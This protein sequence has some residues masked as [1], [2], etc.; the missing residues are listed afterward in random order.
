MELKY[1]HTFPEVSVE[2]FEDLLEDKEF[3]QQLEKLPNVSKR[4]LI[5]E[6]DLGGGKRHTVVRYEARAIPEQAKKFIG[7]GGIGWTEEV[8]F[9]RNTHVHNFR[10]IPT[11]MR[12]RVTCEGFYRLDPLGPDGGTKRTV[13]MNLKV[14]ML[15]LGTI[16]ERTAKPFLEANAREEERLAREYIRANLSA[17]KGKKKK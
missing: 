7:E 3:N 11:R 17:K 2:E 5:E 9:N 13:T 12:D 8:D 1:V 6:K 14:K 4:T 16:A 15:G 10:L